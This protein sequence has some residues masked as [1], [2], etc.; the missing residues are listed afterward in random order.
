M[1]GS[2]VGSGRTAGYRGIWAEG[3]MGIAGRRT[4]LLTSPGANAHLARDTIE[5]RSTRGI[6][7]QAFNLMVVPLLEE[8]A[9]RPPGSYAREPEAVYRDSLLARVVR[10]L[11][12]RFGLR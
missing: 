5:L 6:P 1:A 3:F 9:G 10:L 2:G 4:D 11:R 7:T 8:L 12:K